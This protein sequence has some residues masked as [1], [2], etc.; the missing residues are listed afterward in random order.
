M[1]VIWSHRFNISNYKKGARRFLWLPKNRREWSVSSPSS[2]NY[3]WTVLLPN[4]LNKTL[5]VLPESIFNDSFRAGKKPTAWET[6]LSTSKSHIPHGCL[7]LYVGSEGFQVPGFPFY[8]Y[9]LS[10]ITGKFCFL[11]CS[12]D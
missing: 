11:Y 7:I 8:N 6:E 2:P 5:D 9:Q 10:I 4:V 3:Q 1:T 12:K